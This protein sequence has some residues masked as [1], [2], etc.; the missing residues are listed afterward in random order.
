MIKVRQERLS[1][2]FTI[3]Q[4]PVEMEFWTHAMQLQSPC[5][6]LT[7][8]L[9]IKDFSNSFKKFGHEGLATQVNE[10]SAVFFKQEK[11]AMVWKLINGPRKYRSEREEL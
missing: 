3:T 7:Q 11:T 1:K 5:F 10:Q 9:K 6:N 4:F 2:M 8:P